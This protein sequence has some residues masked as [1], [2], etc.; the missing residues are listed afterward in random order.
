MNE[1]NEEQLAERVVRRLAPRDREVLELG[2]GKEFTYI[3]IAEQVGETETAV[4]RR[5]ISAMAVCREECVAMGQH[6]PLR[7]PFSFD[8]LE[9]GNEP[10]GGAVPR[11][12][13][14]RD[15]SRF[16]AQITDHLAD[17][18]SDDDSTLFEDRVLDDLDFRAEAE[19]LTWIWHCMPR[20]SLVGK[21]GKFRPPT[22]A[23][24]RA[25][26]DEL[27]APLPD[28]RRNRPDPSRVIPP[29]RELTPEEAAARAERADLMATINL[30][31]SYMAA[32]MPVAEMPAF[33]ERLRSDESLRKV[34]ETTMR[35]NVRVA[36]QCATSPIM[37]RHLAEVEAEKDW[38][39]FVTRVG[40]DVRADIQR[41]A[42]QARIQRWRAAIRGLFGKSP[43]S[44]PTA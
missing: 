44:A 26:W 21:D 17:D 16:L 20:L 22:P 15:G 31:E 34:A 3:E 28:I 18:V 8:D 24:M 4:R 36:R 37:A 9:P 1:F 32:D 29:P 42:W 7:F 40:D 10:L 25:M 43:R 11:D 41:M 2:R 30:V 35:F 23:E 6:P 12:L 19:L 27:S 13:S 14:G 39:A 38:D 33:E 5:M